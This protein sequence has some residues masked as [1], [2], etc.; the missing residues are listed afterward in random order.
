MDRHATEA[1]HRPGLAAGVKPPMGRRM[2]WWVV[3]PLGVAV[4]AFVVG[5]LWQVDDRKR[6]LRTN[7]AVTDEHAADPAL[8]PIRLRR[9][10]EQVV[11][12][13]VEAAGTLK[14][15]SHVAMERGPDGTTIRLVRSTAL[16][17][18]R[19]D[20]AVRVFAENGET[21]VAARSKSRVGKADFGQNPRNLKELLAALR[22]RL[23]EDPDAAGP[24]ILEQ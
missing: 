3:L 18:F 20:I 13:V 16:W 7:E 11:S 23:G 10:V 2:I 6:D 22:S 1:A 24:P 4:L 19:D 14:N 17:R 21:V 9:S 12:A 15:W 8:R 5:M